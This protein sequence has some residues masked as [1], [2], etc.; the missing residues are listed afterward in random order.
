M[1]N[2]ANVAEDCYFLWAKGNWMTPGV[3]KEFEENFQRVMELKWKK[4]QII[5]DPRVRSRK[6]IQDSASGE[7]RFLPEW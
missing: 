6:D 2:L 3:W 4:S 1:R 7:F 5:F